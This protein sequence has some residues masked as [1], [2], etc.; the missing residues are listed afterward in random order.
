MG[1]TWDSETGESLSS[2][3]SS[4]LGNQ[5]RGSWL[6][7]PK[8]C[9]HGLASLRTSH[10]PLNPMRRFHCC[11]RRGTNEDCHFWEWL[12]PEL[13]DHYK[14]CISKLKLQIVR[15]EEERDQAIM[16]GNLSRGRLESRLSEFDSAAFE[17]DLLKAKNDELEHIVRPQAMKLRTTKWL[18]C[19]VAVLFSILWLMK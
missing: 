13:S 19:V 9:K 1:K 11:S 14:E 17:V 7:R 5:F 18:F 15:A 16:A 6:A 8:L 12:D 4:G 2:S 10:T 3:S